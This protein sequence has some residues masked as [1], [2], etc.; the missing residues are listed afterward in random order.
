MPEP[1]RP[2]PHCSVQSLHES[3]TTSHNHLQ[4]WGAWLTEPQLVGDVPHVLVN[5][6]SKL[7]APIDNELFILPFVRCVQLYGLG[8]LYRQLVVFLPEIKPLQHLC[9]LFT[10]IVKR[11]SWFLLSESYERSSVFLPRTLNIQLAAVYCS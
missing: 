11:R 6:L 5:M 10:R 8:F 9:Q 2:H 7:V 1:P 3:L 4:T